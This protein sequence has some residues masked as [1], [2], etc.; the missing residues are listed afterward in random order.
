MIKIAILTISDSAAAGTRDDL[1]GPALSARCQQ[2]GWPVVVTEVVP[3]EQKAISERLQ[4]WA[5]RSVATVILTTGGTGISKRDVTPEATRS[6]LER[7]IPGVAELIRAKGLEQTEFAVISRALVG[8]R[9]KSLIV[10]LPGSPKGALFSLSVVER[11]VPHMLD[12]LVGKTEH[13]EKR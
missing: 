13:C 9:Q 6:V 2:L 11:L 8:T 10:N 12:L 4:G 5:D 7:E 1:S 3:D